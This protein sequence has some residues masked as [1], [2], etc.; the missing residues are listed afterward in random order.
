MSKIRIDGHEV[1]ADDSVLRKLLFGSNGSAQETK[2]LPVKAVSEPVVED[3]L[4]R[5]RICH[6]PLPKFKHFICGSVECKSKQRR[7][8]RLRKSVD[9][10]RNYP[11]SISMPTKVDNCVICG[12]KVPAGFYIT[13]GKPE[14]RT[15]NRNNSMLKKYR[16]KA[17]KKIDSK[18]RIKANKP[19]RDV[20][21]LSKRLSFICRRG[22][23]I[24]RREGISYAFGKSK[25][26]QEWEA[27][28]AKWSKEKPVVQ[29]VQDTF[30]K[31][32][33]LTS[34]AVEVL[35]G[36]FKNMIANEG[37]L[38]YFSV[39]D[40]LQ[41]TDDGWTGLKWHDFVAE[42]VVKSPLIA[43]YFGV[44]GSVHRMIEMNG[45]EFLKWVRA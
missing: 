6:E 37:R 45:Y 2:T 38:T 26:S 13:C 27:N 30:P 41:R 1:E 9:G 14:C 31:F 20:D 17:R 16:L 29:P 44:K 12:S 3:V 10:R 19:R 5:C 34:E 33:G 8:L 43:S 24:A 15:K 22:A 32:K 11:T 36:M 25:A 39:R 42:C 7:R 35:E 23:E 4:K 21:Y 18:P 40:S 28:R